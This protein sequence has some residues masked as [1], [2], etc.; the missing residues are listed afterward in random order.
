[1]DPSENFLPSADT[2][3]QAYLKTLVFNPPLHLFDSH[4]HPIEQINNVETAPVFQAFE[5]NF[6]FIYLFIQSCESCYQINA[7]AKDRNQKFFVR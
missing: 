3:D 7:P 5:H 1:L 4:F 2:L 6:T